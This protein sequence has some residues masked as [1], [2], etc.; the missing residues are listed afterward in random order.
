MPEQQFD[1]QVENPLTILNQEE[2]KKFIKSKGAKEH[3]QFFNRGT[4][5]EKLSRDYATLKHC[6]QDIGVRL[7]EHRKGSSHMQ[8]EVLAVGPTLVLE[9]QAALKEGLCVCAFTVHIIC[10]H[11]WARTC[12]CCGVENE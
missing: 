2:S 5:L 1:I 12:R 10:M 3:Y 4:Q 6:Q 8:E 9:M 11:T 7:K